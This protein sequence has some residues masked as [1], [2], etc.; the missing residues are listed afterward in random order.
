MTNFCFTKAARWGNPLALFF[1]FM[2][3]FS[4]LSLSSSVSA[5]LTIGYDGSAPES[6]VDDTP[7]TIGYDLTAPTIYVSTN[8]SGSGGSSYNATYALW[9]YNQTLA[10]GGTYNETYDEAVTFAHIWNKSITGIFQTNKIG[11]AHV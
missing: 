2:F 11:R 6:Q 5:R 7:L 3:F 1:I 4:F 10:S 8:V 9:A